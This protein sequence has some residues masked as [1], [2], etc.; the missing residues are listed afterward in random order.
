VDLFSQEELVRIQHL[1]ECGIDHK[2]DNM[3]Y[4]AEIQVRVGT[5]KVYHMGG[6]N[7]VIRM[8]LKLNN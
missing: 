4:S 1:L 6:N 3:K 8:D 7:P 5:V 2:K